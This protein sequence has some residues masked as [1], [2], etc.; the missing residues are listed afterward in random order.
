MTCEYRST[1]ITSVSRTVSI[2]GHAAD[3]VAPEVDQHD[4]LGPLLG[5]GQQLFG[6][7]A[8][9]GLVGTA[10]PRPRQRP[11]RHHP[12]L[13]PHQDLRR[14]ADQGE[15]AI[16]QIKEKRAGIDHAQH[17]VN[18]KR[19]GLASRSRTAGWERPERCRPP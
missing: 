7:G 16:G 13:D 12:V 5:V 8:V 2:I 15:V 19:R 1:F 6:Q 11:D 17:P 4:V 18:I 9:L 3:V 10:A 14:A